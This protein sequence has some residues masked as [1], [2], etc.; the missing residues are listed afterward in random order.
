MIFILQ[1]TYLLINYFY[2][3]TFYNYEQVV[4]VTAFN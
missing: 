2:M 3:I 4:F 1:I